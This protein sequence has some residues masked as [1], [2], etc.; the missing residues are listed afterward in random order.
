MTKR[1]FRL[2]LLCVPLVSPLVVGCVVPQNR[3]DEVTAKLRDEEALR[4]KS[5][6]ELARVSADLVRLSQ[7]LDGKEQS[8]VAREGDLAKAQL[9]AERISREKT[10]AVELVEQLRGELGRVGE[11]LREYSGRKQELEAALERAEA[12]AKE[13]ETAERGIATKVLVMR[14]VTLALAEPAAAGKVV[15]TTVDGK[16]T[17]RF[18]AGEVFSGKAAELK[19]DMTAALERI[20]LAV[21]PRGDMHVELSDLSADATTSEERIA[22]LERVADLFSGKGIGFER[23]GFAVTP[24]PE[25]TTAPTSPAPAAPAKKPIAGWRDG[26]GSLQI[27][28][29]LPAASPS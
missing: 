28:V 4:R 27:V 13:L 11:H 1:R 21:A 18:D 20:A 19:P 6:A 5:E 12:R 2:A 17:V 10:D 16:P 15:I 26:P 14:D 22:R 29:G 23:L 9:D 3:Y 24:R 8:L 7:A 25:S